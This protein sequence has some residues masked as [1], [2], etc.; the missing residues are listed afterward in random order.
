MT[1]YLAPV[2][3]ETAFPQVVPQPVSPIP[4]MPISWITDG[5]ANTI[6]LV[7]AAP[8]QAVIWTAPEDWE[9]DPKQPR[10][11]LF[12]QRRGGFLVTMADG[13]VRL[14]PE[15]TSDETLRLLFNRHDGTPF[16]VGDLEP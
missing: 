15:T 2:G 6:L 9:F 16:Y 3:P 5:T 4:G 8:D 11:G 1:C 7:E 13:Y 12:G 14:I 10:A